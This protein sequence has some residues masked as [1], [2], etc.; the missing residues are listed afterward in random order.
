[1]HLYFVASL[2][3]DIYNLSYILC[4]LSTNKTYSLFSCRGLDE[5]WYFSEQRNKAAEFSKFKLRSA[6]IVIAIE[7]LFDVNSF[8][9]W[10]IFFGLINDCSWG[11]FCCNIMLD[12]VFLI[13]ISIYNTFYFCQ[14]LQRILLIRLQMFI[15][16]KF[17]LLC[18]LNKLYSSNFIDVH[19]KQQGSINFNWSLWSS[20][21]ELSKT[22]HGKDKLL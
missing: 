15:V 22:C 7:Y 13:Y 14:N 21:L 12:P 11:L 5:A 19:V 16:L 1:M 17:E 10:S 20:K 4:M 2:Y 6:A 8:K 3:M 9:N 18:W